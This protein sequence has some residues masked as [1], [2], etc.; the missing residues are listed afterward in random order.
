MID[1]GHKL[2]IRKQSKLLRIPTSALY[3]RP[4]PMKPLELEIMNRLDA[5][6][7]K[8]PTWGSRKLRDALRLEGYKVNRKRVQRLMRIMAIQTIYPKKKL[9]MADPGAVKYPYL[10]R[11]LKID[12]PGLVWCTDITYI[13]L[14]HGFVYLVAIM[15]WYSRKVLSWQLS[16]TLDKHFCIWALEEALRNNPAPII[17]NSDQGSQFTCMDFL[18]PLLEQDVKISMDGKGRALDNVIIERFWRTLKYDEVYLKEYESMTDAKN[19]IG[20]YID[21]YNTSRPHQALGGL[22]PEMAFS[23]KGLNLVA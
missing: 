7:L 5:L 11:H 4:R 21:K 3:Y 10:L 16:N 20:T 17:F 2:S 9:S 14:S 18:R 12:R 19:Q 22:T 13:R 15:D 23:G 1:P 8:E 6:H